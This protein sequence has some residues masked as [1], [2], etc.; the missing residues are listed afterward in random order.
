MWTPRLFLIGRKGKK[1]EKKTMA[2]EK[3]GK[4]DICCA[5]V[6]CLRGNSFECLIVPGSFIATP[7]RPPV[8]WGLE[9]ESA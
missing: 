4:I 2:N 5:S 1:N 3:E 7:E 6:E 8:V 9:E